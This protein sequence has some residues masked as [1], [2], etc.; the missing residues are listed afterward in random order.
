MMN[1]FKAIDT[2]NSGTISRQEMIEGYA[3]IFGTCENVN[4]EID[5][6]MA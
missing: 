4:E 3:K 2:D 5:K 6:I 1:I